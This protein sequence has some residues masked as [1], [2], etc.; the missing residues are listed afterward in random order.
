MGAARTV[1][2]LLPQCL[3]LNYRG[4]H[5]NNLP[6]PASFVKLGLVIGIIVSLRALIFIAVGKL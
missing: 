3:K 1:V 5:P 6:I 4:V 2:F